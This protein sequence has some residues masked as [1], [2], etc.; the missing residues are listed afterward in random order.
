[1]P[2]KIYTVAVAVPFNYGGDVD[3]FELTRQIEE[4]VGPRDGSGAG[5]GYR[6]MD[7]SS[8]SKMM[9]ER[10]RTKIC[11]FLKEKNISTVETDENYSGILIYRNEWEDEA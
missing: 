11:E 4:R 8:G 1:M 2:D 10:I 9:V 7:W 5:M 6:D 3:A